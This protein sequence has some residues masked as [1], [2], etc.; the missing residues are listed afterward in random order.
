MRG[1]VRGQP[2]SCAS[3]NGALA[4]INNLSLEGRMVINLL[5]DENPRQQHLRA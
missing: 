5:L 2:L 3:S 1:D 4:Y